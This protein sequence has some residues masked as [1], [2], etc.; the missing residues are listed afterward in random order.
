M[1]ED[2]FRSRFVE[3]EREREGIASRVGNAIELADGRDVRFAILAAESFRH[4]EDN[5]RPRFAEALG[6]VRRRLEPQDFAQSAE[7]ALDGA[8]G[9]R[10][11]PLGVGVVGA[12]NA[13]RSLNVNRNTPTR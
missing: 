10:R 1:A 7:R 5:V 2:L 12:R 11:V 6:K 13:R 4:V 3:A 9:V 8:D